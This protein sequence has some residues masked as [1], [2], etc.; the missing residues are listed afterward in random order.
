[1]LN[2]IIEYIKSHKGVPV[3]STNL[4]EAFGK[5]GFDIRKVINTARSE[6]CPICSC[7]KGYYYSENEEEVEK[8]IT[9]LK[10]RIES[11]Q[12]AISG[13][14]GCLGGN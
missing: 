2:P 3:S 13:L 6:G 7:H 8:T 14:E 1:M 12:N 11:I 10:H 4:S 5:S 9:S